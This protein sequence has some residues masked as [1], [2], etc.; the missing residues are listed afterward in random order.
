MDELNEKLDRI[1]VILEEIANDLRETKKNAKKMSLHIDTVDEYVQIFDA[2][3]R[4]LM[5]C[6]K[7]IHMMIE[8]ELD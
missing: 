8:N 1:H 3:F 2:K 5:S 7:S 6:N 4:R